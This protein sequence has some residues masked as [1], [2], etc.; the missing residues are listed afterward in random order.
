MKTY[1]KSPFCP[2]PKYAGLSAWCLSHFWTRCSVSSFLLFFLY[3]FTCLALSIN[4]YYYYCWKC[5]RNHLITASV[6]DDIDQ[7]TSADSGD[8]AGYGL[9]QWD[10]HYTGVIMGATASQI[11]S[12]TIVT[13]SFIQTQIKE[14]IKAPRHWPLC[15]EFTGDW[16]IPRTNGQLRGKCFHL[17]TSSWL[18]NAILWGQFQWPW[19][20]WY[21][22][23]DFQWF[24]S[25]Y[26]YIIFAKLVE[27]VMK[28]KSHN[29]DHAV[30]V[31]FATSL[32]GR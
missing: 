24:L 27:T 30:N 18:T 22:L 3:A 17:M 29:S 13:Q 26:K 11:T 10:I 21:R 6:W 31:T 23:E 2:H 1:S 8:H 12:L 5:F 7:Q 16:C 15:R 28:W 14:N 20:I 25:L 9:S 19:N 4:Y 32:L